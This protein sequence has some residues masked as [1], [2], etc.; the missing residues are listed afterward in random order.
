VNADGILGAFHR[1]GV[2]A[3]LIGGM[4]FMLRHQPVLTFDV[5]LWVADSDENLARVADALRDIGARWGPD[6]TSWSDVPQ[7]FAWLRRQALFCLTSPLGAI[8]IFREVAGLE[9]QWAACRARCTELTTATGIP[10][11]SLSDRDMLACQLALPEAE[12]KLDRVR[13]LQNLLK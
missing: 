8:D 10:Y 6:E 4:N 9:G 7:D 12:R 5:D 1:R 13:F 11:A 3:I 2:E